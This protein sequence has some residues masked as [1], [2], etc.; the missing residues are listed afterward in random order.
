MYSGHPL[1]PVSSQS[2]HSINMSFAFSKIRMDLETKHR[3]FMTVT[4]QKVSVMTD[5]LVEKRGQ[6]KV[7]AAMA[8][9][10]KGGGGGVGIGRRPCYRQ[11]EQVQMCMYLLK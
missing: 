10:T 4:E 7:E 2:R 11:T 8:H 1:G 9:L 3:K 5:T 6:V